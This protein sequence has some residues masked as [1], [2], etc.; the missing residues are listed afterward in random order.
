M[1]FG[2]I[3][4]REHEA[5]ETKEQ[6]FDKKDEY[7]QDVVPLLEKLEE[8]CDKHGLP[9]LFWVVYEKSDEGHGAGIL[10]DARNA[11][12]MMALCGNI[13]DGTISFDMLASAF[14]MYEAFKGIARG[15][16]K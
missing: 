2:R 5:D 16:E 7:M 14:K 6:T 1:D 13:A 9:Y 12:P 10:M 11:M 3:F 8:T 15:G 4:D